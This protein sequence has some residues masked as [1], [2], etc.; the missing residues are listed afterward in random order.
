MAPKK[1]SENEKRQ[2]V[3]EILGKE[4]NQ[5]GN[6]WPV[7]SKV[8]D[9]IGHTSDAFTVAEL[10]PITNSLLTGSRVLTVVGS[11]ALQQI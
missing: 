1:L 3:K 7:F 9:Y 11:T 10:I 8:L 6:N 4:Y 2:L 5:V